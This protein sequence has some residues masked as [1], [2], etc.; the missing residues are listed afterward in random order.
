MGLKL[1]LMKKPLRLLAVMLL[2]AACSS[3]ANSASEEPVKIIASQ[4]WTLHTPSGTVQM[5]MDIS[6]DWSKPQPS[7]TRA[8]ILLHGKGRDVD[9]YYRGL[10]RAAG[11][12]GGASAGSILIAPQF[13]NE[14]DIEAHR[15]GTQIVR[16]HTGAW[17]AGGP[18]IDPA[19]VSAYEVL[20]AMLEHLA[21]KTIFPNLKDVVL[22]GH[23][24]GGQAVQRYAVVG[25]AAAQLTAQ[26]IHLRFVIA[27]P[28]SY[29][30]FSD[31]RP[32]AHNGCS[33]WDRWKY[34]IRDAPAYVKLT[35]THTWAQ[36]EA[37]FAAADVIY[38]MGDED[39]DP[40]QKDLDTSCMGE[41][42]GPTRLAR[43]KSFYAYLKARHADGFG[44]RLWI[45]DGVA[46]NGPKMVEAPCGVK[47]LFGN[48]SCKDEGR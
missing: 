40:N 21:D 28:S 8:V 23:S 48:G 3:V 6:L 22:A 13:L 9:G 36:M 41:A 26:G 47:A 46:H 37:D 29:L 32:A 19:P 2:S 12:A 5:P 45:V 31:E 44:Q 42:E 16:W 20:D 38:L 18:A 14:H 7:V 17:E 15:L 33:G 27:N 30:Y 34:G 43:G 39:I 24:G 1:V 35:P 4:A 25:T 10:Q 11:E